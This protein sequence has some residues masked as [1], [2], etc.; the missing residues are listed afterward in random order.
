MKIYRLN[1]LNKAIIGRQN[2]KIAIYGNR[3]VLKISPEMYAEIK[4]RNIELVL[5]NSRT[6]K[7]IV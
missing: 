1:E 7:N 5:V 3:E 6:E 4:E 2:C